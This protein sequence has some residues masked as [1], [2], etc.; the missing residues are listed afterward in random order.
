ML[1]SS[2]ALQQT[3]QSDS[4]DCPNHETSLPPS[5]FP[6]KIYMEMNEYFMATSASF[7]SWLA[8]KIWDFR[9]RRDHIMTYLNTKL[10]R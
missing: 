8:N 9:K 2:K 1:K 3:K 10:N 4:S 7:L 5:L 6:F